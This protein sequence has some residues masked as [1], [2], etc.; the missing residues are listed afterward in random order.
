ME[1]GKIVHYSVIDDLGKR[2]D[3]M[4]EEMLAIR[5]TQT[6]KRI[7]KQV[8]EHTYRHTQ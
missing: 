4:K 8:N 7:D 2:K 5:D 3:N 6:D 1:I